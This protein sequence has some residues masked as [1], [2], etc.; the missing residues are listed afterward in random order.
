[1]MQEHEITVE[2]LIQYVAD[3]PV[4]RDSR[5]HVG[6]CPAEKCARCAWILAARRL[7][8]E[9]WAGRRPRG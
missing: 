6:L 5:C 2:E 9:G 3:K 4:R 8:R 1:M 7:L